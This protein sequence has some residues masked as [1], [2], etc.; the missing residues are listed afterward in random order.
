MRHSVLLGLM[1]ASTSVSGK[2]ATASGVALALAL[3]NDK[4]VEF[5]AFGVGVWAWRLLVSQAPAHFDSSTDSVL[6]SL[7]AT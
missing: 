4:T 7:L 6:L 2:F 5:L 1:E 3:V